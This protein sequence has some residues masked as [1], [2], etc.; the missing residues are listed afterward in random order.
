MVTVT[1]YVTIC[2]LI[3]HTIGSEEPTAQEEVIVVQTVEN[4]RSFVSGYLPTEL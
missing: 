2:N 4:E 1:W 3:H